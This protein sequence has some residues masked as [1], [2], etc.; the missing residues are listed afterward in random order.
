MSSLVDS[1]VLLCF[2]CWSSSLV[3]HKGIFSWMF[4]YYTWFQLTSHVKDAGKL[5]SKVWGRTSHGM[6]NP[7]PGRD[8]S[9]DSACWHHQSRVWTE[10][11]G[12]RYGSSPWQVLVVVLQ[13]CT[14][15]YCA[16]RI[17]IMQECGIDMH[18]SIWRTEACIVNATELQISLQTVQMC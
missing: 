15:Q 4:L 11:Q 18:S 17:V 2:T 10:A 8:I 5:I 3:L 7:M 14:M 1:C 13:N 6:D 16:V 9:S 12:L